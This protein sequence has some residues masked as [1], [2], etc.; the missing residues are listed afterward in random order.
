MWAPIANPSS[1]PP[2]VVPGPSAPPPGTPLFVW[3]TT[4]GAPFV[5]L[6][7]TQ[8]GPDGS[9]SVAV[10][11]GSVV[12]VST[13]GTARH[14]SFAEPA[15]TPA[16]FPLPYMDSFDESAYAY[17]AMA[18]FLSDQGGS[19]AVRNGSLVQVRRG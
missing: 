18:R 12:T 16:P 9:F 15:P 13:V 19:W 1:A 17:D 11:A 14:G 3:Q 8:V 2:Q 7:G 4:A 6:P 5:A 10:G